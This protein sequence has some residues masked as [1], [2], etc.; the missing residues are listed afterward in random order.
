MRTA[1]RQHRAH[2][3]PPR[4][5]FTRGVRQALAALYSPT[6]LSEEQR[7]ALLRELEQVP[8]RPAAQ[9]ELDLPPIG[10]RG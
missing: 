1:R 9:R 3:K 5:A 7:A 8:T 10:P 6:P 2:P 4:P